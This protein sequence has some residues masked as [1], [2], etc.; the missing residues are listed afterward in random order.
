M[1]LTKATYSMI[2]G[3][4]LNVLDYG[5]DSTGV[6]D[7]TSAIQTAIT[8][9][10]ASGQS[11]YLPT[12]T[13]KITSTLNIPGKLKMFGDGNTSS[14]LSLSTASTTTYALSISIPDNSSIIGMDLGGFGILGNAGA[15]SG[16]GIY[17]ATTATNSAV[18]Q[19]IL[20]DIYIRN[21]TTGIQLYGIIYMCTFRNITITGTVVTYGWYSS[22]PFNQTLYNSFTDLEVTGT[23][24]GTYAYYLNAASCQMRNLTADGCCYFSGA[25][26]HVQGLAVEGITG[27]TTPS[28]YC[29]E[30]NQI[31]SLSDV[32]LI[33][34]PNSKCTYGIDIQGANF[35]LS[36]VRV[37]NSGAGNQPNN[38]INLHAGNFG[39]V[40]NVLCDLAP[41]N[42]IETYLSDAILNNFVISA[43]STI[44]NRNLVYKQSTWTP[45]FVGW[46]TAP[47]VISAQYTQVGRQVTLSLYAQNGVNS[48][49]SIGG[50][51]FTANSVQSNVAVVFN[52]TT[53][54]VAGGGVIAPSGT[55]ISSMSNMT[56][57]GNYWL[58]TVT[59]FV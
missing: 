44:T 1:S 39:T 52:Q 14:I 38:I 37:P 13:Y 36:N 53:T 58:L 47:T 34:V 43:C 56:F 35:N 42:L 41:V 17:I 15:A 4:P 45:T 22:N 20:H 18:S 10:I 9:C 5:A 33:N 49:A 8:S 2:L 50:I 59:Y 19:S 46:G 24:A 54:L 28:T 30:A 57:T 32:A 51:P 25:Y 26:T 21:V 48:S 3:A 29:I 40:S 11:L 31:F 6:A 27:A 16:C 12:G 55:T 23:G 7:S